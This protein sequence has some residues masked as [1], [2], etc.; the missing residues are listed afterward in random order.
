MQLAHLILFSVV[1]F[2]STIGLG[3]LQTDSIQNSIEHDIALQTSY[4]TDKG[5]ESVSG[6]VRSRRQLFKK[7]L[8]SPTF[9]S[10]LNRFVLDTVND[11][12]MA[13]RNISMILSEQFAASPKNV[14]VDS[15]DTMTSTGPRRPEFSMQQ[16]FDLLGS[17]YRGL[18]KLFNREFRTAL[19]DSN[20]NVERYR[21]E[22]KDSLR[23]FFAPNSSTM[24]T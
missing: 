5:G 14:T 13:Y 21:N 1:T 2:I 16:V 7:R 6:E 11:T 20:K 24:G 3:S 17:N 10:A 19:A 15:N 23:P 22:L 18:V 9:L 4:M 12:S 8:K